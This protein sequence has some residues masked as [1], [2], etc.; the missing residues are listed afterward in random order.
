MA[1]DAREIVTLECEVCKERN[2][3]TEKNTKLQK[4]RLQLK[5]FCSKCKKHTLHKEAK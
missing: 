2:Y 3:Q 4:E 1:K 5:K